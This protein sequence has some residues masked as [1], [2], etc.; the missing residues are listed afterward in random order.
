MKDPTVIEPADVS[1]TFWSSEFQLGGS[2]N[3]GAAAN[4]ISVAPNIDGRLQIF[5]RGTGNH[6]Y[7]NLQTEPNGLLW[8]GET[9]FKGDSALDIAAARNADGRLEI[10]YVGTNHFLYHNWQVTAGQQDWY[11]ETRFARDSALQI[12]VGQN[13][14]GSLET[15]YVGTSGELYHNR[16]VAPGSLQWSG[17]TAL[18]AVAKQIAVG[19]NYDGRLEIFYVGSNYQLYHNRQ[20]TP[21]GTSWDGATAFSR[22]SAQQIAVGLNSNGTL[23]IFYVGTNDQLYH[24]RQTAA[25]SAI[26]GGETAFPNAS[27][28]QVTVGQNADG[29]LEIFYVGTNNT[30][31]HNWQLAPSDEV[32]AGET[33]F[34]GDNSTSANA[35]AQQVVVAA[36]AISGA[37][38]IFYVGTASLIVGSNLIYHRWQTAAADLGSNSNYYLSSD[39]VPLQG[40]SVTIDITEDLV[41][42]SASNR[43]LGFSFQINAY[44]PASLACAWQQYSIGNF[45]SPISGGVHHRTA[46]G[47]TLFEDLFDV[48]PLPD[49]S[50]T[51]LAAGYKL[52]IS[53]DN[54]SLGNVVSA[55][56]LVI[57]DQG[58]TAASVTK[59]LSLLGGPPGS[60][61]PITA[62]EVNLVGPI[63]DES[64]ILSSGAGTITYKSSNYVT[65]SF[66]L[67][68]CTG[69]TA[70]AGE[71]ANSVYGQLPFN[72]SSMMFTQ[73]FNVQTTK[74][75]SSGR[76]RS[77]G[78]APGAT[79]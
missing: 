32:W 34:P 13:T 38:E 4:Q 73:T 18:V 42:Q 40:V 72:A 79:S 10:F 52:T 57:D 67:P 60:L 56:Y 8:S 53:L 33:L 35:G 62:F 37:L 11:G 46:N 16:Q 70:V 2:D 5:Y 71:R 50:R 6:L 15:F 49:R 28:K 61:A 76:G 75:F 51:R 7:Y 31:Y 25:N 65:P 64:S 3:Q 20:T 17:E 39:C 24:N 74:T 58:N 36:N 14:D 66:T 48:L 19:R 9:P 77:V 63:D 69:T 44:S 43:Q 23:E 41:C 30:L 54:D 22:D 21:G 78:L 1:G 45:Q 47:Q 68:P 12:A 29:H 26:W 59:E 27:A 55:T